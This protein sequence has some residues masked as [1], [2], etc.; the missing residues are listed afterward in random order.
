MCSLRHPPP[1]Q[2][3]PQPLRPKITPK[4]KRVSR[5]RFAPHSTQYNTHVRMYTSHS[6]PSIHPSIHTLGIS[7]K[8]HPCAKEETKRG[9][10]SKIR[11]KRPPPQPPFYHPILPLHVRYMQYK[12]TNTHKMERTE[13]QFC[14]TKL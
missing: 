3:P 12:H 10:H 6:P 7:T 13:N 2:V 4:K 14:S 1:S 9:S 11:T 8:E 5:F